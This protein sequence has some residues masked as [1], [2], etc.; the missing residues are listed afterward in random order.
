MVMI[1][2]NI[3]IMIIKVYSILSDFKSFCSEKMKSFSLISS[4]FS[5]PIKRFCGNL[6]GNTE[7]K[8]K[9]KKKNSSTSLSKSS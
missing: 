4:D 9:A 3:T 1:M 6:N 8:P 2:T 5:T 7:T